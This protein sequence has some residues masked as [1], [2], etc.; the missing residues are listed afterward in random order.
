MAEE[1]KK[2][3]DEGADMISKIK[4]ERIKKRRTKEK[5]ESRDNWRK[6]KDERQAIKTG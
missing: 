3:S 4:A 1:E 6:K 2:R 5:E